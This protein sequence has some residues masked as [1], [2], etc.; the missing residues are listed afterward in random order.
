LIFPENHTLWIEHF[1]TIG[2]AR[3]WLNADTITDD[4]PFLGEAYRNDWKAWMTRPNATRAGLNC[5]RSQ[6]QGVQEASDATLTEEDWKL[7]VPVLAI[8][9]AYDW[10][11]RA[12]VMIEQTRPWAVAGFESAILE[13]GHWLSLEKAD[14]MNELL[15]RFAS[16]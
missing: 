15:L 10:V 2:G 4:P 6:L 5:Y 9:G 13:G 8:A 7:R 12:D 1:S 16:E 11:A 3:A 14:E